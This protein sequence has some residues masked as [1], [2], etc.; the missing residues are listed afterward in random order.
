MS[1]LMLPLVA[2]LTAAGSGSQTPT[3][4]SQSLDDFHRAAAAADEPRY[5][6]HFAPDGVFLGTDPSERWTV[7]SF[8][9]Y[10]HPFFAGGKGWTYVSRERHIS[11][12]GD[13]A[14]FDE[15]L[16]NAKYGA[17][18][19]T[20]V[21]KRI[22]GKWLIAQYSLTFLVPNSVAEKVTKISGAAASTK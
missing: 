18:R 11:I 10:A 13:V 7:E 4:I 21:L 8:R 1:V 15:L 2:L 12:D 22:D 16:D 14:W 19:G 9:V 5:F 3:A 17:C 6:G 20:G